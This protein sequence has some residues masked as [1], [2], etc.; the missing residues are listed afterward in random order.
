MFGVQIGCSLDCVSKHFDCVS[1][2]EFY[3]E[4]LNETI[5]MD[6]DF[7]YWKMPD[8]VVSINHPVLK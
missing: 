7:A 6:R 2:Q 4:P 8:Q 1:K 3:N 5:E